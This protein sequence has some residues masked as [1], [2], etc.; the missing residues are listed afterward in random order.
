MILG[1]F[2]PAL[3]L[4]RAF[5]GYSMDYWKVTFM[6]ISSHRITFL[7]TLLKAMIPSTLTG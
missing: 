5:A 3:L 6:M 2:G 1:N 7:Q 4:Y